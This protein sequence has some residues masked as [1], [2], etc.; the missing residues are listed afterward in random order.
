MDEINEVLDNEEMWSR[1]DN[2]TRK[3]RKKRFVSSDDVKFAKNAL[4]IALKFTSMQRP[5]AVLN[6]TMDEFRRSENRDGVNIIKVSD[7]KTSAL[8][9]AKLSSSRVLTERLNLYVQYIRPILIGDQVDAG[10]LFPDS[11]APKKK[12]N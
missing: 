11:K 3:A 9:T 6:C 5:G 10:Y 4:L 7:H 2:T 8:G 12:K 1:F